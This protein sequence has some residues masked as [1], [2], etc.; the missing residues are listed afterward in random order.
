MPKYERHIFTCI[1][2]REPGDP[3]GCCSEKGSDEIA[4]LF[5]IGLHKRGLKGR[6]RANKAGCLDQCAS[7]PTVVVYPEGV[8]YAHVTP[9]DVEEIIESHLVGG[10]IVER[11]LN[12]GMKD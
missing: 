10:K 7:G 3:K 9:A 5:K 8:W 2:R 11:L 1:N 6:M 12:P 4:E